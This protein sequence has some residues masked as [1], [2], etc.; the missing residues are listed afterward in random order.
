MERLGI[1][2]NDKAGMYA[3]AALIRHRPDLSFTVLYDPA[4]GE[5]FY[6][7][8]KARFRSMKMDA[9]LYLSQDANGDFADLVKKASA[10]GRTMGYRNH[11]VNTEFL[12]HTVA[13]GLF[14]HSYVLE[15]MDA[16]A[17]RLKNDGRPVVLSLLGYSYRRDDFIRALGP[18]GIAVTDPLDDWLGAFKETGEKGEHRFYWTVWDFSVERFMTELLGEPV[19]FRK[20]YPHP[21]LRGEVSKR[22]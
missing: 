18:K 3:A 1:A 4:T 6:K 8:N 2:I 15:M 11:D 7:K 13:D 9:A 22:R 17:D 20:Y 10:E 16:Y 14:H 12:A 21:W 5:D 19:R